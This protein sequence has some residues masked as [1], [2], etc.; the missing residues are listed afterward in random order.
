MC[1]GS[2]SKL[3]ELHA[4]RKFRESPCTSAKS[5]NTEELSAYRLYS[6]ESASLYVCPTRCRNVHSL[7]RAMICGCSRCCGTCHEHCNNPPKAVGFR[8]HSFDSRQVEELLRLF[9]CPWSI[10]T[11]VAHSWSWQRAN[12]YS[13][14]TNTL[15]SKWMP[16]VFPFSAFLKN[17][18]IQRSG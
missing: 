2:K 3:W 7:L 6:A 8:I 18:W 10:L 11:Y 12:T 13:S 17:I 9:S 15:A 5:R 1:E 14:S 4:L 16:Y